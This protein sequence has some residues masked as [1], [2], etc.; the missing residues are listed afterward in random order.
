MHWQGNVKTAL[1]FQLLHHGAA[2]GQN[3]RVV[4]ALDQ[5]GSK[6]YGAALDTAAEQRGQHLENP[7]GAERPGNCCSSQRAARSASHSERAGVVA[8]DITDV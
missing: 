7:H 5:F 1:A 3:K 8:A 2:A 4:A 6:F